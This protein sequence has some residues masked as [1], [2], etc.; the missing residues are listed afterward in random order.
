MRLPKILLLCVILSAPAVL[1]DLVVPQTS[2]PRILI[3]VA[4]DTPGA[5]GTYFRSDITLVNV[6]EAEQRVMLIWYPQEGSV[7]SRTITI[8]A[9]S[10]VSSED[11]V[12]NVLQQTG[13]GAIDI[14]AV[15]AEGAVDPLGQL[16]ATARIWTPQ[17]NVVDGE[18]SQ[19]FPAI[20]FSSA[21]PPVK[22]I[23]GMRRDTAH[24]LNVGIVNP[25]STPQRFRITIPSA[26]SVEIDVP[27]QSVRQRTITGT[28]HVAQIIVQNITGSGAS[29]SWHAWASSVHN[30]TGDAWSQ[31][32]FAA[33]AD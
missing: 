14:V 28:A 29:T 12:R 2:A 21:Q 25:S 8:A 3:P 15:N 26:E 23:F 9:R 18:M 22:W 13:I 7:A 5:N 16:H 24:R 32:A 11:F 30:V 10:G 33:P 4:G 19:P 6:R 17:P 1:A 31:M 20:V 27:A